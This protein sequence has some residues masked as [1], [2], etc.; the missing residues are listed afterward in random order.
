MTYRISHG[1]GTRVDNL[2][3]GFGAAVTIMTAM[4]LL[5]GEKDIRHFAAGQPVFVEGAA[6]DGMYSV[7]NGEVEIFKNGKVRET[8]RS[9]GFFGELALLDD[10]SRSATA[11]ARTA[12]VRRGP[13]GSVR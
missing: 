2:G 8:V 11:V 13:Q 6:A 1:V 10:Q 9:G 12:A 5:R 4:R 7:L 3:L